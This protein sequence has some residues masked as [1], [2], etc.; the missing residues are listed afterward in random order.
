MI[1]YGK[2]QIAVF[3]W[4]KNTGKGVTSVE[5]AK[6]FGKSTK[7]AYR[8]LASLESSYRVGCGTENPR[9]WLIKE[10]ASP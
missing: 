1:G 9:I 2:S 10:R 8:I 7:W 5:V 3:D 6:A 4:I